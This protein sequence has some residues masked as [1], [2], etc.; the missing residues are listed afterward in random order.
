M[1]NIILIIENQ[2]DKRPLVV[3]LVVIL[4]IYSV[5]KISTMYQRSGEKAIK[6][7]PYKDMTYIEQE[8]ALGS[9]CSDNNRMIKEKVEE[10]ILGLLKSPNSAEFSDDITFTIDQYITKQIVAH[11]WVDAVN[12]YGA[13]LRSRYRCRFA[14]VGDESIEIQKAML[15]K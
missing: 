5:F 15:D 14:V 12:S 4:L 13:K 8:V 10:A 3:A 7:K 2:I 9:F 11:G 6:T 1:K